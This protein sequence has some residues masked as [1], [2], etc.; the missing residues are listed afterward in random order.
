M[1]LSTITGTVKGAI[2][3]QVFNE[4]IK[5]NTGVDSYILR[6]I[7]SRIAENQATLI[8]NEVF[9]LG[10][11]QL[12]TIP[13][14]IVGSKNPVDLIASNLG[15]TGLYDNLNSIINTQITS[16]AT[17]R[18]VSVLQAELQDILPA[19]S[20]GLIN[21]TAL[22]ATL[23]QTIT[24]TIGNVVN[25]TFKSFTDS[26]FNNTPS[27][28]SITT[29]IDNIFKS[30]IK[31]ESKFSFDS[32]D[33]ALSK[34]DINFS[35]SIAN[36][37]LNEAKSF[38][39]SNAENDSKLVATKKGFMDPSATYPTREYANQPETNKLAR[40]DITG[41]VVQKKNTNRVIGAKLPNFDSFDEPLS[42]YNGEYPFNKVTQTESGHIIEIDDT[43][44][45]ERLHVYH[46]S[47]TYIE[48]DANG[49]VV[50]RTKGSS[51]EIIDCNGKI[52]I[53]GK[54]DISV[55]GA[56]NVFIGND[57]NM[58]V[59]GDVNLTCHNDITAQAGGRIDLSAKEEINIHSG[60]INLEADNIFNILAD[61]VLHV[62]S[63]N[64][65]H[66]TSNTETFFTSSNSIN[67]AANTEIKL[68]SQ[69][70]LN[71]V[72][73]KDVKIQSSEEVHILAAGN[74]N[75]D[76]ENAFINSGN[77]T[78][79]NTASYATGAR[80]SNI[81]L[82]QGRMYIDEVSITDP[83]PLRFDSRYTEQSE[84][85]AHS[86]TELDAQKNRL[87]SSG[88]ATK[89]ELED[90]NPVV[91]S[92]SSPVSSQKTIL[93]PD[94]SLLSVTE[95]PGNYKLTPNYTLDN[96]WKTVAVSPGKHKIQAQ[97]GLTYGQIVYNLQ[98]LALNILEPVKA[99]YPKMIITSCF[100]HT[101]DNPKSAH[102]A[103]LAVD[104]QFP[105]VSREEYYNI[106]TKLAQVLSY[107]Q[108][109]LE[110]WAQANNPWIHISICPAGVFNPSSQRKVAWT[111]KDHK[112]F[113]QSLVNLA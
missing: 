20:K 27:V 37:T 32:I 75:V 38:K 95:L 77:A 67:L 76:G 103:G 26:I 52:A 7:I 17:N 87:I 34:I 54:A 107:D 11:N 16:Q 85:F 83:D 30:F 1:D 68:L 89:D 49:S 25:V 92:E 46:K 111:F 62:M 104:M 57:C 36:K 24:P 48:I 13:G 86:E 31:G 112:L 21:F 99:L 3:N 22:A 19:N 42:P 28:A 12:N 6:A 69:E 106:A 110:Y 44:G 65:V 105:G 8:V 101:Q 10:N 59:I 61:G 43:P 51:Y 91:I 109:L 102:P 40:G 56:C 79:A 33:T 73:V 90:K 113:K 55:N 14:Q 64:A 9:K 63:G 15:S 41:T 108:I 18:L 93:T 98:A 23:V 47:G 100:R 58:E 70:N 29:G 50:K 66:L 72:S 94:S 78:G 97:N 80:V 96:M 71:I 5:L 82:L 81:G 2:E 84:G 45:S 53:M 74:F 60:N 4:I 35:N 39:I 88:I